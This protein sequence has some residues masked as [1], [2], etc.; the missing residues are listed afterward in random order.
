MVIETSLKPL[1]RAQASCG[2]GLSR[3]RYAVPSTSSVSQ[4][5]REFSSAKFVGCRAMHDRQTV[6]RN[7]FRLP[8]VFVPQN[9]LDG[10][11][12]EIERLGRRGSGARNGE[13]T[14]RTNDPVPEVVG[15]PLSQIV[16]AGNERIDVA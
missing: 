12:G 15:L 5:N 11:D 2:S 7:G 13:V 16:F 14:V 8:P 6:F 4:R 3:Q 9:R 10:G 1:A